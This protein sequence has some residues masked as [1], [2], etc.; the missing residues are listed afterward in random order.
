M[1][2]VK[3]MFFSSSCCPI[4]HESPGRDDDDAPHHSSQLHESA[5]WTGRAA[6]NASWSDNGG[7][8]S[9]FSDWR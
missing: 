9:Q 3:N 6:R 1:T 5:A 8:E 2:H 4:L 7:D